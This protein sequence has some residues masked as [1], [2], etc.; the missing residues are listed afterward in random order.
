MNALL[1][2]AALLLAQGP[3]PAPPPEAIL[4]NARVFTADPGRPWAE[5]FAVADGRIVAV[6]A[7]RDLLALAGPRTRVVD[8]GGAFV[9]PGFGDSHLHFMSGSLTLNAVTLDGLTDLKEIQARIAAF[10]R[11]NPGASWVTG[12]G[13]N[14]GAFPGN[15]P[16]RLWLDEVVPDRP[17]F[18]QGYD[19]HTGWANTKALELAGIT[20]DTKDPANGVIVR[21]ARGEATGAL[22]EAA[23]G[24]VRRLAPKPTDEDKYAALKAGLDLAASYGLTFAHNAGFDLADLPIY[25]R[26]MKEGGLKVRFYNA[27]PFRADPDA[28]TIARYKELRAKHAGPLFRFG[29]IKALDD[30][31]VESKTAWMLE[32][33]AGGGGTG[34]PNYSIEELNR[35]VAAFDREGFQIF[36]HAIGDRAIRA[37][38][39]AYENAARV[40]GT[41]GRRHRVEHVEA[42]QSAEIARFKPLGVIAST[43]ALFANPDENTLGAYAGALGPERASR[44]MAF[45]AIDE[46]GAVQ[47]FGS[48]WPVFS[49]EVLRGI[50]CAVTRETPEGTPAGGW[51]PQSRISAEAALRHFTADGAWAGFNENDF[52]KIAPGLFADFV[53]LSRDITRGAPKDILT[54]RVLL[55]VVGGRETYRARDFTAPALPAAGK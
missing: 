44:A 51:Q 32:P 29:A 11:A 21:D 2:A 20:R 22:K 25:E 30:G 38:L 40:N 1:F 42:P 45:K 50:Y 16:H 33:Y 37:T 36:I 54:T 47:A 3:V 24:L 26:V 19:G 23:Q 31:V 12:R 6:G 52:G 53:V 49:M 5:A 14:Y 15:L 55:T 35:G 27:L 4:H 9:S 18:M 7:S 17:A 34:I 48:D 46:A 28:A 41:S 43:Q 10:A 39:D 8:L 13:W